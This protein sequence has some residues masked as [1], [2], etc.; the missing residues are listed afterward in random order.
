VEYH[1]NFSIP[2]ACVVFGLVAVPLGVQPVRSARSRGF[3]LSLVVIFGYYVLFSAGQ[4]LAE[5]GMVPAIVGLWLPNVI[6][7]AIGVHLFRR[8]AR[9]RPIVALERLQD[10][11]GALRER[12]MARLGMQASP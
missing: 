3:A 1:R 11:V 4:A 2:F 12:V 8:A 7:G 9:E 6:F 10:S 5:Q